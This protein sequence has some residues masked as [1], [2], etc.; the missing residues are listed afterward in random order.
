MRRIYVATSNKSD[1]KVSDVD[2]SW[3]KA[4]PIISKGFHNVI[5]YAMG[6]NKF[7][8]RELQKFIQSLITESIFV[9]HLPSVNENSTTPHILKGANAQK[10][11]N[12]E[13]K[14]YFYKH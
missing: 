5:E 4:R 10:L 13:I 8:E 9:E 11:S 12:R 6:K 14:V 1:R 2:F 3:I 7:S